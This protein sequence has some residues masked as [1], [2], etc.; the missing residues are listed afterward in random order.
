MM[1]QTS[2]SFDLNRYKEFLRQEAKAKESSVFATAFSRD[3]SLFAAGT[4]L[5]SI[6]IWNFSQYLVSV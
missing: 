1:P 6:S 5:G 4:N 2:D 3:A